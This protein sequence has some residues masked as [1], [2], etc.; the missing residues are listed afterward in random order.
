[1]VCRIFCFLVD[2]IISLYVLALPSSK[3][4]GPKEASLTLKMHT[5]S[6]LGFC[7]IILEAACL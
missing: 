3:T 5:G 1:M 6:R 2:E 7:K 4:Q